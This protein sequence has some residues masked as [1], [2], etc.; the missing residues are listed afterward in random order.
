ME[1]PNIDKKDL[2]DA[3]NEAKGPGMNPAGDEV[4]T[5]HPLSFFET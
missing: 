5:T 3:Y 4:K 2:V 1:A